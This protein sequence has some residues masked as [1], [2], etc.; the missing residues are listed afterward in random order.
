[1]ACKDISCQT[2]ADGTGNWRFCQMVFKV[3]VVCRLLI[4]NHKY[5]AGSI[6]LAADET[7]FYIKA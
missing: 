7:S 6:A 5:G 1:M 3:A 4:S 2:E